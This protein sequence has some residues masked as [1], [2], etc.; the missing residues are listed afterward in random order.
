[1]LLAFAMLQDDRTRHLIRCSLALGVMQELACIGT[2]A[3]T[4]TEAVGPAV[5]LHHA[6]FILACHTIAELNDKSDNRAT[7]ERPLTCLSSQQLLLR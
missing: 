1:M 3:C 4:G 6:F 5:E 7:V 2:E